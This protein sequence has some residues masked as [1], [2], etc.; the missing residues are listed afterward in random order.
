MNVSVYT[1]YNLRMFYRYL[2]AFI[3]SFASSSV[4]MANVWLQAEAISGVPHTKIYAMALKES[5]VA[6][7]D[8]KLRP[9]PWTLNSAQGSMRFKTKKEAYAA[10]K[11]LVEQGLTNIDIGVM[12]INLRWN[13]DLIKDKDILDPQTNV[14]VAASLLKAHMKTTKGDVRKSV[15]LYHSRLEKNATVYEASVAE[16]E[17]AILKNAAFASR[18]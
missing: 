8:S 14:M 18:G 9:W 7:R 4:A 16:F 5:G 11:M 2:V 6:A 15:A 13:W 17:K 10:I 3:I 12:Q 1:A